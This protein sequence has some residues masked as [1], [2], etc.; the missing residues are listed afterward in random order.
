[1]YKYRGVAYKSK[2]DCCL[3]LGL[4]Y[5]NIFGYM[6]RHGLDFDSALDMYLSG[7][8]RR[9][10]NN[11]ELD[12]NIYS[13]IKDYCEAQ[14]A[15]YTRF[16][17]F[18]HRKEI[19]NIGE[20][21]SS[22]LSQ[23]DNSELSFEYNDIVYS[24]K[25]DCCRKLGLSFSKVRDYARRHH[26][27]FVIALGEY[28]EGYASGICYEGIFYKSRSECCRVLGLSYSK[29][30]DYAR[31]HNIDFITALK[32]YQGI[33][34]GIYYGGIIY[35][36]RTDCCKEYGLSPKFV[37]LLISK[38]KCSFKDAMDYSILRKYFY[39]R[40]IV[41][42][43]QSNVLVYRCRKSGVEYLFSRGLAFEYVKGLNETYV[44]NKV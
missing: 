26:V 27:D 17:N 44:V 20:A 42:F 22:Y 33:D 25:T 30:R 23:V 12:G 8:V 14:G 32:K 36:S 39:M 40:N 38:Y 43:M 11:I 35:S 2:N 18:M 29:V 28:K 5:K 15:D 16:I 7:N 3:S 1:M 34:G 19:K 9:S 37:F 24:S 13:S 21:M 31:R 41:D 10:A 6:C 4:N